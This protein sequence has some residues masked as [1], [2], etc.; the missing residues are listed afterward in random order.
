[1]TSK[2]YALIV[3][4]FLGLLATE[5][6]RRLR[7]SV[8]REVE[9]RCEGYLNFT[10]SDAPEKST[11]IERILLGRVD[12]FDVEKMPLFPKVGYLQMETLNKGNCSTLIKKWPQ[13][14]IKIGENRICVG[15]FLFYFKDGIEIRIAH[16]YIYI[17][18]LK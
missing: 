4:A 11:A 9:L 12:R 13:T 16:I 10:E 6:R 18:I 5:G 17:S 14:T 15:F 1:M 7:C 3:V 8:R 2:I